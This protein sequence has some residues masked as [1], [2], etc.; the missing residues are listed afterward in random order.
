MTLPSVDIQQL[1]ILLSKGYTKFEL[2]QY[3]NCSEKTICRWC[4][5]IN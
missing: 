5:K 3:F 1:S 2:A 4:K